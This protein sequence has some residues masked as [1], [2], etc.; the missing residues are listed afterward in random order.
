MIISTVTAADSCTANPEE[1]H[2]DRVSEIK[3]KVCHFACAEGYQGDRCNSELCILS[4]FKVLALFYLNTQISMNV[5][6][7]TRVMIMQTVTTPT[8]VT[9]ASAGQVSME[10]DTTVQVSLSLTG[11]VSQ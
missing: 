8:A 11:K 2:V 9:G 5:K 4:F 3:G 10:M 7:T 1:C 6:G